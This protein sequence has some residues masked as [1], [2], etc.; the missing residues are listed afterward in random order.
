VF[1]GSIRLTRKTKVSERERSL[2]NIMPRCEFPQ[3]VDHLFTLAAFFLLSPSI[4][5]TTVGA[6]LH[7]TVE[8]E[9]P[10]P[11]HEGGGVQFALGPYFVNNQTTFTVEEGNAQQCIQWS[12]GPSHGIQYCVTDDSVMGVLQ[13]TGLNATFFL[14]RHLLPVHPVE[15]PGPRMQYCL[16]A[17]HQSGKEVL[18]LHY[19]TPP[20]EAAEIGPAWHS[21]HRRSGAQGDRT[22]AGVEKL[23]DR[24]AVLLA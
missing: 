14:W 2:C 13:R 3:K 10:S 15:A 23:R 21:V 19:D 22:G 11:H 7:T 1:G 20:E 18:V 24:E 4:R 5:K 12:A 8:A 16:T 9:K 6:A 17:T